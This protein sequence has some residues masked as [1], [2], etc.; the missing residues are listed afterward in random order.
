MGTRN[1]LRRLSKSML[2]RSSNI[3]RNTR[4]STRNTSRRSSNILRNITRSISRN[5][6]DTNTLLER[7]MLR[8]D[9]LREL[10]NSRLRRL[11]LPR[12]FALKAKA[13]FVEIRL[14]TVVITRLK[15]KVKHFRRVENNKKRAVKA[16]RKARKM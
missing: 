13:K 3:L 1:T 9:T 11:E 14:I 6:T 15:T 4:R 12:R 5:T 8:S 16:S 2:R 10:L 7:S